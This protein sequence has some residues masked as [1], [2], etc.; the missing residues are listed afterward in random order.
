MRVAVTAA[1]AVLACGAARAAPLEAYGKLPAMDQVS[2]SPDGTKVAFAQSVSGKTAVVVDQ[3]NPAA[4]LAGLPPSD[5]KVRALIWADP[6]HLIVA[7]SPTSVPSSS[8]APPLGDVYLLQSLDIDK[9]KSSPLFNHAQDNLLDS[10]IHGP[11][12]N[13]TVSELPQV[14][15]VKG[16][17]IIFA[18]GYVV[19]GVV[20][21]PALISTDLAGAKQQIVENSIVTDQSRRWILNEQGA[22]IALLAFDDAAKA[23]YV[24]V[25]RAGHWT[26]AYTAKA[27]IPPQVLGV[28]RDGAS[29]LV[30]TITDGGVAEVRPVS[31]ADGSLGA[32]LAEYD[33]LSSLIHD[34]AT[35]RIV[36]GVKKG[37][38]PTYAFFDPKD[39]AAWDLVVKSFP[40]GQVDLVSWSADHSKVV[41]RVTSA[42]RG[43]VYAVV[44]LG[45]QKAVLIG[46]A[47]QGITGD[48]L[49]DVAI[50][51]YPAK[52]GTAIQAFLTL[53]IGRE[54]KNLPMI[55]L[56]H[57]G[58]DAR[59]EAG[60]DW[61]AQALASRG[62]AVLQPQFRGSSGLGPK[63]E[64]AGVGE[65]G[66]KM[67]SDLSDGVRA[68]AGK[69]YVDPKRVC[70]VGASY[71]GYAA[72]AGVTIEQG[73]YRC[74]V[75][76]AGASDLRKLLGARPS[77]APSWERF[78]GAK[79]TSDPLYDQISPVRH[80][81]QASGPIL[82]IHDKG[83]LVVP[84]DQSLSME[85][86]LK[87]ANKPVEFVTLPS[88]DHTLSQE[89]TRLQLLQT[90]VA[91]LEKNNPPK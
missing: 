57:D 41:V 21:T 47:Y 44:D 79:G 65:F 90:T 64:A 25:K 9:R 1:A 23:W 76:V 77:A 49:A 8:V 82:L 14:G 55:V 19:D 52:D 26:D 69:G 48:D 85:T 29:V 73:V 12:A 17:P 66:R 70:I 38:E 22:P 83:D 45:S 68:L 75:A 80:A 31:I 63:L 59:V 13:N 46:Q 28:S 30:K 16:Q 53:P 37:M 50:V 84:I 36:G 24:R 43:I 11:V 7:K 56:A 18:R 5:Q 3:L 20:G 81:A 54:P 74:A 32:P 4:V 34:P 27:I 42:Q 40:D 15:I 58:P 89:A 72:L 2:I 33:S 86:A 88:E 61:W 91:F 39:Q 87:Q 78:V 62:Y 60:F 35:Q 6:T 51:T 71:G 10:R 67:Q